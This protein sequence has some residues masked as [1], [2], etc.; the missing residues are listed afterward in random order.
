[1]TNTTDLDLNRE[2][3]SKLRLGLAEFTGVEPNK[4]L[5]LI[6]K[7]ICPE[8]SYEEFV[9]FALVANQ[10]KLNPFLREI[11][12]FRSKKS[13]KLVPIVGV[14]GWLQLANRHPEF[15]GMEVVLSPDGEEATCTIWR[16]DRQHPITCTEYLA[17]CRQGTDNWKNMPRRML[18]HK[19][20]MQCA[21]MAFSFGGI[22]DED[23]GK[24]VAESDTPSEETSTRSVRNVTKRALDPRALPAG[25]ISMANTQ[26]AEQKR[27]YKLVTPENVAEVVEEVKAKKAMSAATVAAVNAAT[28]AEVDD[29]LFPND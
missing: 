7:T 5:G 17:E 23:E 28:V 21:R 2:E 11:Y 22:F 25:G 13:G 20:I 19:A 27:T 15:D 6:K 9:A 26:Q 8:A 1:M 16:K 12:A 18:R 4:V 14:D 24:V 10:Y 3:T 29:E